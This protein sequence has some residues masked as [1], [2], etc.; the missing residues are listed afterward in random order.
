RESLQVPFEGTVHRLV[1][2]V[3]VEN[4]V[5]VRR[6][7]GAQILDMSVAADLD[8]KS[9]PW[10]GRQG[11]GH[12]RRRAADEAGRRRSHSSEL[13]RQHRLEPPAVNRP[14]NVEGIAA[15][16]PGFEEALFGPWNAPPQFPSCSF[17]V[18]EGIEPVRNRTLSGAR[19]PALGARFLAP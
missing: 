17:P 13:D 16:R 5:A 4:E 8:V 7:I 9:R 1:E 12:D 15:V 11:G 2:I 6:R 18:S 14:K 3:D 19:A 10:Q